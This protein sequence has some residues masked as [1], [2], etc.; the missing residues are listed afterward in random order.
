MP[1]VNKPTS[2]PTPV[3]P[4]AA[5]PVAL[6]TN[7]RAA[8]PTGAKT[9]KSS[10]YARL[11]QRLI[12]GYEEHKDDETDYGQMDLPA[13]IE[14]GVAELRECRI[15]Q[16]KTGA[17]QGK[18]FFYAAAIVVTPVEHAGARTSI[19]EPLCDTP[20]R[21]VKTFEEHFGKVLNHIAKLGVE[22]DSVDPTQIEATCAA[23]EQARPLIRFRTWKGEDQAILNRGGKFFVVGKKT[24]KVMAGPYPSEAALRQINKYVDEPS[25][26]NHMW[27]GLAP[28]GSGDVSA[29]QAA[30]MDDGSGGPVDDSGGEVPIDY[31]PDTS[32]N[33][34]SD[35]TGQEEVV[36]SEE[37]GE[38][39]L[40]ALA[41]DAKRNPASQKV[42]E[43]LALGL[44]IEQD[45]VDNAASWEDVVEMIRAAQP[46]GDDEQAQPEPEEVPEPQWDGPKVGEHYLYKPM[47]PRTKK[48]M[49]KAREC[50]VLTVNA[51]AQTCTLKDLTTHK[52]IIGA[53]KKALQIR[54]DALEQ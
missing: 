5:R 35:P 4:Q 17:M 11:G 50:E 7:G 48:P 12:K 13:G 6:P 27:N 34:F 44:G 28:D 32:F 51:K 49:P 38:P 20:S 26:V 24:G 45:A 33:E 52:P 23:L 1:P 36:P 37:G 14:G 9:T 41:V 15:S 25:R 21:T 8:P 31:V 39:D 22:R 42:L 2:K 10:L 19:M 43:E 16:Y 46:A 29:T 30:A 3:K 18:D 54:W 53:D 47:D 40:D